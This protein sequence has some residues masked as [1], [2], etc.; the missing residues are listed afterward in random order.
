MSDQITPTDFRAD[1]PALQDTVHLASCSQGALSDK[2][3]A[4]M[5]DFQH[6]I[7]VHGAPWDLWM[8]KVAE[9]RARFA[10]LIGADVDEIAVTASASEAAF[11]VAST[12]EWTRRPEIVTTDMEF[13]SVAH[14]WLAQQR[15]GARARFV[16]DRDGRVET[17]DY[18]AQ[19]DDAAGLVSVPLISYRNGLRLPVAQIIDEAQQRGAKTF[20]DAYQGLGVEP[21]DVKQLGCDYLTSGSL[22]YLLGIP[23]IAFLYVRGG[24]RDEVPPTMTGWFGRKD[25]FA[26]DPRE[27]DFPDHARRFESGTP[28][29]PSAYGAVA[30]LSMLELVDP[31]IV[32]A[33]VTALTGSLREQ[34]VAMGEEIWSPADDA[35]RGPQVALKCDDPAR[36]DAYLKGRRIVGSPRGNVIRL[37]FHYYN[38]ESDV[39]AVVRALSEYRALA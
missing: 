21:V 32:R 5:L 1:F 19:I 10:R 39:E 22:K 11:Q 20:V 25:P 9:A 36:L 28:S 13:P 31:H 35:R 34:L 23:G 7:L 3:A 14:V 33:H 16:S 24:L 8:G 29:I 27:I 37:S 12:Q 30:G 4:A 15:H 17:D 38:N 2:L 6:S 18:L 26:F